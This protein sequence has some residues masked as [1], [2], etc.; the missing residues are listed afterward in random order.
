MQVV[1]K[2]LFLGLLFFVSLQCTNSKPANKKTDK[3]IYYLHGRIIEDQ[4]INAVSK[5][6]GPYKYIAILKTLEENGLIVKSEPRKEN[7]AITIYASKITQEIKALIQ[8]GV[9]PKNITVLGASKGAIITMLISTNLAN[10]N[11]KFVLMGNCN[12]WVQSNFEIDLYGHILS[13]YEKSDEY[14]KSCASIIENSKHVKAFKEITLDTD[15]GHGFL[16]K[17]LEEWIVPTV[18][19]TKN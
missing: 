3:Y 9:D 17:P 14:G 2:Y 1:A 5:K 18:E 19:W 16:Y 15:L 13:I 7:T 10:S 12:D 4:G 11:V 8:T 6:Y